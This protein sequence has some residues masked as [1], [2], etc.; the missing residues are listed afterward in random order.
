MENIVLGDWKLPREITPRKTCS[1]IDRETEAQR[2]NETY[3]RP[4]SEF[5]EKSPVF[6]LPDQP[7]GGRQASYKRWL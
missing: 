6:C 3:P 4:P 5:M 7:P 1:F 2:Q